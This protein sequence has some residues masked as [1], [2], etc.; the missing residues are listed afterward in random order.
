MEEKKIT[1][2]ES[3]ELIARMIESTKENLEVGRGNRFLYF[4]YF[5][6]VLSIVVFACVKLTHNNQFSGLW[7]L[8]FLCWGF[9][10]WKSKKPRVVTY[11]DRALNSVWMVVGL[12]FCFST[13]YLMASAFITRNTDMSLMMPFSL[14]FVSVGTSMTGVIIRNHAITYLPLV[15]AIVSFYMLNSFLFG[16]PHVWWHL[17]FGFASVF[18]M[19]IPGHLLNVKTCK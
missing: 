8:M 15:S 3:L 2:Q 6:F 12:M 11:T 1:E 14:L 9:V 13:V 16:H 18:N 4:G 17:L 19:I 5:A 10:S 7:W